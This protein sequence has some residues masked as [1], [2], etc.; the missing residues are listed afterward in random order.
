[1]ESNPFGACFSKLWEYTPLLNN[2]SIHKIKNAV[3]ISIGFILKDFREDKTSINAIAVSVTTSAP[4]A[5]KRVKNKTRNM[6]PYAAYKCRE[7]SCS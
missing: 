4:A 6:R 5:A 7:D 2:N 1:M 3:F